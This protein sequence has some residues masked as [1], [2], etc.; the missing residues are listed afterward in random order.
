MQIKMKDVQQQSVVSV[1]PGAVTNTKGMAKGLK[2]RSQKNTS[3]E[4]SKLARK[5]VDD[6]FMD[7]PKGENKG[8]DN[9][10]DAF[11]AIEMQ[12]FDEKSVKEMMHQNLSLKTETTHASKLVGRKMFRAMFHTPPLLVS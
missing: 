1:S 9:G 5:K 8:T 4:K 3:K 6:M 12:D 7:D 11:D 10:M 2:N